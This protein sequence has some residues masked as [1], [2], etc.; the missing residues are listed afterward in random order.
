MV[1]HRLRHSAAYGRIPIGIIAAAG[2]C[3]QMANVL[4]ATSLPRDPEGTVIR[5]IKL[6]DTKLE[7][8]MVVYERTPRLVG[9]VKDVREFT[10]VLALSD[11]ERQMFAMKGRK[12]YFSF[13]KTGN[14]ADSTVEFRSIAEMAGIANAKSVSTAANTTTVFNGSSFRRRDPGGKIGC[15]LDGTKVRPH[16]DFKPTYLE[17][18]GRLPA[19]L[20]GE[21]VLQPES[22]LVDA[23]EVGNCRIREKTEDVSGH[24][25]HVI[26][27][28][29]NSPAIIWCD[30]ALGYAIR[31]L[32]CFHPG[33][34]I[35]NGVTL[36]SDF[37][38]VLEG[39]WFPMKVS[40]QQF[41]RADAPERLQNVPL[42][43]TE[44]VVTEMDVNNIPD[45]TFE[46]S[47]PPGLR[48]LDFNTGTVDEKS[49]HKFGTPL[50]VAED[51]TLKE[52]KHSPP[53]DVQPTK[54]GKMLWLI[55]TNLIV[56]GV[57][58]C[59]WLKRRRSTA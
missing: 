45:S 46:L 15:I 58:A 16:L 33:T 53:I 43:T 2:I 3:L 14:L 29:R 35:L 4:A 24:E 38:E 17:F 50:T 6:Q 28:Q 51:G 47:F 25:C 8:F 48:V 30:P 9:D 11:T 21:P 12:R 54:K 34:T 31:K 23:I 59:F 5:S 57:L 20:L 52:R 41:A 18:T 49:G 44:Y 37:K 22:R 10:T 36:C 13:D 39:L 1:L 26:E 19:D 27:W 42:I 40:T 56:L 55:A 32:Q 7:S